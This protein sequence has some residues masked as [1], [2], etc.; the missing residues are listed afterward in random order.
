MTTKT[1]LRFATALIAVCSVAAAPQ[2]DQLTREM[3]SD[4]ARL[5]ARAKKLARL[6][7]WEPPP[8]GGASGAPR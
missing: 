1:L 5:V 7:P 6:W 4:V 2:G 3:K 8:R